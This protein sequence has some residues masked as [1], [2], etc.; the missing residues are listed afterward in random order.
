MNEDET[1]K[2]EAEEGAEKD[3]E[4][5]DSDADEIAGGRKAGEN[6]KDYLK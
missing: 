2:E 5:E 3:L 1:R 4:L 6:P